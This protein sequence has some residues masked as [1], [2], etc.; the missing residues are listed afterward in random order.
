MQTKNINFIKQI[1]KIIAN[2]IENENIKGSCSFVPFILKYYLNRFYNIEIDIFIGLVEYNEN[3]AFH[4]W[5]EYDNMLIDVTVHKQLDVDFNCIILSEQYINNTNIKYHYSKNLPKKYLKYIENISNNPYR[6]N[7]EI[8]YL[9]NDTRMCR[10]EKMN[11]NDIN[12]T[13][14]Y[15]KN[16]FKKEMND[17]F[18]YIKKEVNKEKERT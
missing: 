14:S 6:S 7:N 2:K 16:K 5:N 18:D 13:K 11:I 15:L 1:S 12:I 8:R 10:I 9:D 17:Y 4:I 3:Y